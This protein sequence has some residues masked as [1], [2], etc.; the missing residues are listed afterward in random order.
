[1]CCLAIICSKNKCNQEK[2]S[3]WHNHCFLCCIDGKMFEFK[4][5]E[6][7]K[8]TWKKIYFCT[9]VIL[10]LAHV[11]CSFPFLL[12]ALIYVVEKLIRQENFQIENV[13]R[14]E[15]SA[16]ALLVT[17]SP[18]LCHF[19]TR[20]CKTG[21]SSFIIFFF[22]SI[23]KG[24]GI[25]VICSLWVVLWCSIF[26][27]Q[28]KKTVIKKLKVTDRLLIPCKCR[29]KGATR[30]RETYKKLLLLSCGL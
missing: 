8:N 23:F 13:R 20:R 22:W 25:F 15:W 7:K 28:K 26:H 16:L 24:D 19:S 10:S 17:V 30:Q 29:R 1:M 18:L 9:K 4:K 21:M 11:L 2:L 12:W 27:G 14:E 3:L 5:W 6:K